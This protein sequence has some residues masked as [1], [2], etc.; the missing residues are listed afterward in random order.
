MTDEMDEGKGG[1]AE[2]DFGKD[3]SDLGLRGIG[4]RG[5]AGDTAAGLAI[6]VK[7]ALR[8]LSW[9]ASPMM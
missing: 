4:Q 5:R 2:A 9:K 8:S 3:E 7:F 6:V 1:P